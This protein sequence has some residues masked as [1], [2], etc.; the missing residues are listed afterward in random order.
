MHHA[1]P[2]LATPTTPEW[3]RPARIGALLL[4]VLLSALTVGSFATSALS[5]RQ[6]PTVLIRRTRPAAPAGCTQQGHYVFISEG[7][8]VHPISH[9]TC[10]TSL[11]SV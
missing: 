4:L 1:T 2:H 9:A 3:P 11:Q 5:H 6:G 8:R 7:T 10:G